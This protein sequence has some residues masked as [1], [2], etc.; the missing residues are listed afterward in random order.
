MPEAPTRL[1]EVACKGCQRSL[2][3]VDRIRDQEIAALEDHLRACRSSEP[4]GVAPML[5]EIMRRIQ[6]TALGQA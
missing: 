1:F 6:V 3:I 2:V 4:L 5:G